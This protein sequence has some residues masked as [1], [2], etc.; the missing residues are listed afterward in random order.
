MS[1]D[2]PEAEA[3]PKKGKGLMMKMLV[4]LGLV[5]SGGGAAYGMMQAGMI[6]AGE[7][8]KEDNNPKLIRKGEED[9]YAPASKDKD[10]EGLAVHGEGGAIV[11][12]CGGLSG[13]YGHLRG[14]CKVWVRAGHGDVKASVF[15]L[16]TQGNLPEFGMGN[17]GPDRLRHSGIARFDQAVDQCGKVMPA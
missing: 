15:G 17:S 16:K 10:D 9:P 13:C 7:H 11:A 14:A 4:S 2:K 12:C 3:K 8:E 6:G 1:S 5:G